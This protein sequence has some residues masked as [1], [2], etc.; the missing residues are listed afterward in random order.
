MCTHQ[1]NFNCRQGST[2]PPDPPIAFL[3]DLEQ[4]AP[5]QIPDQHSRK[6]D[7]SESKN[8]QPNA[9]LLSILNFPEA[10]AAAPVPAKPQGEQAATIKISKPPISPLSF[11]NVW[12]ANE[13]MVLPQ[14]P[15]STDCRARNV[16][17]S[18]PVKS[19][20]TLPKT[21]QFYSHLRIQPTTEVQQIKTQGQILRRCWGS[22]PPSWTQVCLTTPRRALPVTSAPVLPYSPGTGTPTP[23]C[24]FSRDALDGTMLS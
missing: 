17:K 15:I 14:A 2:A 5:K 18:H 7:F 3:K 8:H 16:L 19:P 9:S 1:H 13:T 23:F 24:A 10:P 20:P 11:L 21:L 22:R 6:I 12:G 4:P